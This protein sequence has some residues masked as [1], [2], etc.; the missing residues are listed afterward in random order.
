MSIIQEILCYFLNI[1]L[2]I[3]SSTISRHFNFF[4]LILF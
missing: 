2:A 4:K 3:M 1:T